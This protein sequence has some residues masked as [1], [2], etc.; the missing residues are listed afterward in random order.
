M[1]PKKRYV[2]LLEAEEVD[3]ENK[4][5]TLDLIVNAVFF[6]EPYLTNQLKQRFPKESDLYT[7]FDQEF[8][9]SKLMSDKELEKE[10]AEDM[11]SKYMDSVYGKK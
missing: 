7:V 9:I 6:N 3:D 11:Y 4:Q 2:T 8:I 5:L 10:A 1:L